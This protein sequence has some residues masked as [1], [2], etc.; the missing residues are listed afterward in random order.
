MLMLEDDVAIKDLLELSLP[1]RGAALQTV[2]TLADLHQTLSEDA[3]D[4]LLMDL[5]PVGDQLDATLSEL[6]AQHPQMRLIV[7]S[8]SV[9]VALRDDVRWLRKPFT[10]DEL[11]TTIRREL[12][13]EDDLGA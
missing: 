3:F 9:T 10:P 6:R 5:S 13:E 7:T 11:A 4:V 2:E 8:G 1:A 12:S